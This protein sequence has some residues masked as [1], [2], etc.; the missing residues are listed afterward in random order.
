VT[1]SANHFPADQPAS[2]LALRF[3]AEIRFV[4]RF[5]LAQLSIFLFHAGNHRRQNPAFG[6]FGDQRRHGVP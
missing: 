5:S 1:G 2:Q 4:Q 3:L 6:T